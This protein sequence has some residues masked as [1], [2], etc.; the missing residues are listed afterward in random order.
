MEIAAVAAISPDRARASIA[1]VVLESTSYPTIGMQQAPSDTPNSRL[2]FLQ[3]QITTWKLL[4]R[5]VN[6]NP[7]SMNV[8][9]V[10]THCVAD[11]KFNRVKVDQFGLSSDRNLFFQC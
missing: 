1:N 2:L 11:G 10:C 5:F 3:H 7:L 4:G 8:L 6:P 9:S